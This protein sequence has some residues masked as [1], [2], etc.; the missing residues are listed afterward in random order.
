MT[1]SPWT[2]PSAESPER[3]AESMR[4][5]RP[6]A[7]VPGVRVVG[8]HGGAGV[9]AVQSL[10]AQAGVSDA[11]DRSGLLVVCRSSASG[12][13][14]ARSWARMWDS[15]RSA[16][17]GGALLGLVVINDSPGRLPRVLTHL[18]QLTSGGFPRVWRLGW[19][20]AWR[21]GEPVSRSSGPSGTRRLVS[22]VA[23]LCGREVQ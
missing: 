18:L 23:R 17:L 22:D 8:A 14:A 11:P 10:L 3:A 4:A 7:L 6:V 2:N 1:S 12:L 13:E 16:W 9:S 15:T 21:R 19:C 5:G 20:E